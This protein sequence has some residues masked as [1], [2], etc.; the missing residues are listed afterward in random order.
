[1]VN[2]LNPGV[3]L[4]D[5]P[6]ESSFRK[7][8][9]GGWPFDYLRG[10]RSEHNS[11]NVTP[12]KQHQHY[13]AYLVVLAVLEYLASH[14]F[15]E[16]LGGPPFPSDLSALSCLVLLQCKTNHVISFSDLV[17]LWVIKI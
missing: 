13:S 11:R 14:E 3:V 12:S 8:V 16:H 6:G 9:V 4:C 15:L 1:M 10:V 2:G 17:D 7:T 5:H